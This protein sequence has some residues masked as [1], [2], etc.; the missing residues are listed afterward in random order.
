MSVLSERIH[1]VCK[2]ARVIGLV[3]AARTVEFA[4]GDEDTVALDVEERVLREVGG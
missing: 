1:I 2:R 4:V 3:D